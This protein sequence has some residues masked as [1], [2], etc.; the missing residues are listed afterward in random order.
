MRF[1]AACGGGVGAEVP[2]PPKTPPTEPPSY[3]PATPPGMPPTM[4]PKSGAA[5]TLS[6]E[7]VLGIETG[8]VSFPCVKVSF[9]LVVDACGTTARPTA[10]AGG[11]GAAGGPTKGVSS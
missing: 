2:V 6:T 10:G 9:S 8:A 7:T 1:A 5:A 3:P 11:G 4:P